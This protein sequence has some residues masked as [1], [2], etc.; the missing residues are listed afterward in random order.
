MTELGHST[1]RMVE[2]PTFEPSWVAQFGGAI[3]STIATFGA[4]LTLILSRFVDQIVAQFIVLVRPIDILFVLFATLAMS[5]A[6]AIVPGACPG[7][8]WAGS[9]AWRAPADRITTRPSSMPRRSAS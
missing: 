5:G 2:E 3:V 6:A 4:T 9:S 1:R 8:M 7:C